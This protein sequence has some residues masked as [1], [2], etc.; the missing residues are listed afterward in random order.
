MHEVS[1]FLN[2]G[3]EGRRNGYVLTQ[4]GYIQRVLDSHGMDDSKAAATPREPSTYNELTVKKSGTDEE[5]TVM[6]CIPYRKLIG[7]LLYLS[8]FS[9]PDI[10]FATAILAHH[11]SEPRP[12][13]WTAAKRILRYL[14]GTINFRLF[15]DASDLT[16]RAYADADW[17][18]G[19]NRSSVTGNVFFLGG[20][21]IIYRS[22]K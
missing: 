10:A 12:L 4:R 2:V 7:Q 18:G 1:A 5:N 17:A 3:I 22:S 11:M 21:P 15:I 9:R 8:T 6:S 14:R 13:H 19:A 20:A 16:L